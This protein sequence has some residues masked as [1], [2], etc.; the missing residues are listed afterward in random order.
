MSIGECIKEK[1]VAF[2]YSQER[3]AKI[4]GIGQPMMAQIER[5]SKVPNMLLGKSIAEALECKI[6]DLYGEKR[7]V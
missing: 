2:G 3:L 4:I 5:G 7:D 6:E 1:R